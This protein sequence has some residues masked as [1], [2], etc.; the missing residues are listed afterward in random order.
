M[1]HEMTCQMRSDLDTL[2]ALFEA[3]SWTSG[4]EPV[5]GSPD[6]PVLAEEYGE[7]GRS[8]YVAFVYKKEDGSYGCRHVRC[9]QDGDDRGP[10]FRSPVEA[11]KHQRKNHF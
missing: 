9:F 5:I 2:N 7:R 1:D 3:A 4:N 8:C 11:I 6:C 10:S